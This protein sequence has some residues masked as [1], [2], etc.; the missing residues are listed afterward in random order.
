MKTILVTGILVVLLAAGYMGVKS[1]FQKEEKETVIVNN[2]EEVKYVPLASAN[3][4][5]DTIQFTDIDIIAPG[6][7]AN[8]FYGNIQ[9]VKI[10][11]GDSES[12]SL[13]NDVRFLWSRLQPESEDAYTWETFDDH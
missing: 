6:R 9:S 5:F 12:W 13:D 7:G 11:D 1:V 10:P 4:H 8:T 3:I 2:D